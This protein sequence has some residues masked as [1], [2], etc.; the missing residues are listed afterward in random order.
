MGTTAAGRSPSSLLLTAK[1]YSMPSSIPIK[2][3]VTELSRFLI[4]L[5]AL[6]FIMHPAR[7]EDFPQPPELKPDVDF[8]V[9]IF[10]RYST[11]EG[12]LHDSR[13]LGVVYERIDVPPKASR[14][15]RNRI[16]D[17]RRKAISQ[18]R[19]STATQASSGLQPF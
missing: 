13:N 1:L 14:R 6:L 2:P 11:S 12:V 17:R 4:A 18:G 19:T 3:S 10:T 16:V 9:S 8:W 7:A 5:I 15:E